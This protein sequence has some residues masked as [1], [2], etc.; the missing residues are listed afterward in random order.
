MQALHEA[1]TLPAD[2]KLVDA[3][4]ARYGDGAGQ[5]DVWRYL[6]D[7][8]SHPARTEFESIMQAAATLQIRL[9]FKEIQTPQGA[10]F[11]RIDKLQ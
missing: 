11:V 4:E 5:V 10:A 9:A 8:Q 6:N 1:E 7:A 2:P 3:V